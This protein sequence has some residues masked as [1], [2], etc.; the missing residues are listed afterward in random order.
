MIRQISRP[1]AGI[2]LAIF[3][4]LLAPRPAGAQADAY[5]VIDLVN[6]VRAE[7]GLPALVPDGALM[8]AAQSH[9]VWASGI[10]THSHTG[11][12]GSTPRDRAI[13]AGYGGGVYDVSVGE[14]IY[15][16]TMATP[17]SAVQWWRNSSLHFNTMISPNFSQVGVGV[18]Y[19]DFGG[20]FTLMFGHVRDGTPLPAS[21]SAGGGSGASPGGGQASA[22]PLLPVQPVTLA[23]PAED[24]SITHTVEYGQTLWDIAESYEVPLSEIMALNRLTDDSV[25]QPGDAIIIVRSPIASQDA[26][27]GPVIHTVATGQTLF[28]IAL[29]YGIA[30][31]DL[32]AL[33]ALS[34][35]AIIRPGDELL[36]RPGPEGENPI[37]RPPLYHTVESEQTLSGIAAMYGVT[38]D[39]LYAL[40]GLTANSVIHIGDKI[41]IRPGDPTPTPVPPTATPTPLPTPTQISTPASAETPLPTATENAPVMPDR[42]GGNSLLYVLIGLFLLAGVGLVTFGLVGRAKKNPRG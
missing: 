16:G 7:Y 39:T 23:E 18:A 41:L 2:L 35:T 36:I 29:S 22:A 25:I 20:F 37:L 5:T 19:S 38:L 40:N 8:A 11:I 30:L 24:G 14:N 28:E 21:S 17:Q 1:A 12:G 4:L 10:G 15:Y 27:E 33:N 13:A 3:L 31:E 34:A 9:S 42:Q 6:G 26:A 32:L